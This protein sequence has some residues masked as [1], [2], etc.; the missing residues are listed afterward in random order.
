MTGMNGKG[1]TMKKVEIDMIRGEVENAVRKLGYD[2][3]IYDVGIG[4]A[5]LNRVSVYLNLH[6]SPS[7]RTAKRLGIYDLTKHTF[8]D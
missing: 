7:L 4:D 2:L 8:V 3:K 5:G 1:N 6:S